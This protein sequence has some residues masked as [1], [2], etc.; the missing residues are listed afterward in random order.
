[1]AARAA[2]SAING[3]EDQNPFAKGRLAIEEK[4]LA[5]KIIPTVT[6]A[7]LFGLLMPAAAHEEHQ[8]SAGEPGNPKK[9]SRIV[10]VVMRDGNGKKWFIP[11]SIKA[12][13]GEQVRF[14][15]RNSGA[16]KHEF[17]LASVKENKEH[18]EMM[19]KTGHGSTTT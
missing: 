4:W 7:L 15:I 17:V 8:F 14:I 6:A 11:D 18:A 5:M 3:C 1:M 10:Q 16:L 9:P 12:R 19:K 2:R 13:K